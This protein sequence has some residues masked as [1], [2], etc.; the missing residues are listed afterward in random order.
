M[1]FLQPVLLLRNLRRDRTECSSGSLPCEPFA[2]LL[3]HSMRVEQT[4]LQAGPILRVPHIPI[5]PHPLVHID[6]GRILPRPACSQ[7]KLVLWRG[8]YFGAISRSFSRL[9]WRIGLPLKL[10]EA[11]F[12]RKAPVLSRSP[13]VQRG[14]SCTPPPVL[15]MALCR[16][17]LCGSRTGSWETEV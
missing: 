6:L 16:V 13:A 4:R 5:M 3:F 8:W 14:H 7:K 17:P 15:P 1:P 10:N 2:D 12:H 11:T 9:I